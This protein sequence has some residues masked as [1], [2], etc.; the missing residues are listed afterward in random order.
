MDSNSAL[1]PMAP[2]ARHLARRK[3]IFH[4]ASDAALSLSLVVVPPEGLSGSKEKSSLF[5]KFKNKLKRDA[6]S[7]NDSEKEDSRDSES[8]LFCFL[9]IF[10]NCC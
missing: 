6:F 1:A 4:K 9:L 2:T 5:K 7:N 8:F 3:V 10:R